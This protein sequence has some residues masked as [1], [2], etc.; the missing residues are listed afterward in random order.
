MR[1]KLILAASSLA[2]VVGAGSCIVVLI[3]V[4]STPRPLYPPVFM[5]VITFLLP[6]TTTVVASIF[7][8]RHTA[9][10]RRLQAT[11]TAILAML[12]SLSM[13]M[14]ASILGG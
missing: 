8:Y 5:A 13:I 2:A 11:L 10:R 4:F 6:A 12:F 3:F 7:V 1:L 14:T 9:R